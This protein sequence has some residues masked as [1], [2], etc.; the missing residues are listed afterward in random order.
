MLFQNQLRWQLLLLFKS[1][2][3]FCSSF[4]PYFTCSSWVWFSEIKEK[5][6]KGTVCAVYLGNC[7]IMNM[8]VRGKNHDLKTGSEEQKWWSCY[9]HYDDDDELYNDDE[10]RGWRRWERCY[11]R[12][13]SCA[14]WGRNSQYLQVHWNKLRAFTIL[15]E[16]ASWI[17]QFAN[18]TS[19]SPVELIELVTR[20]SQEFWGT[21][22]HWQIIEKLEGTWAYF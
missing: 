14:A 21:R 1:N 7:I 2:I 6:T 15:S 5:D 9:N 11:F 3:P 8:H 10:D 18:A 13:V 12:A 17:D 4:E 20:V 22:E 19:V 16:L